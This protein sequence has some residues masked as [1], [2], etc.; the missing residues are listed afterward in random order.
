MDEIEVFTKMN[1]I[2]ETP[3]FS[4]VFGDESEQSRKISEHRAWLRSIRHERPGTNTPYKIGIYI[5][6]FNQTKYDN[7]LSYHKNNSPTQSHFVRSGNWSI[8]IS[9]KARRLRIWKP[10]RSGADC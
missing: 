8:S 7:Y 2:A 10:R 5:R 6:Y 9:T 4:V 3:Q 1:E